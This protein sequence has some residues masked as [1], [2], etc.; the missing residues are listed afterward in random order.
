MTFFRHENP[1]SPPPLSSMGKRSIGQ[2]SV[3]LHCLEIY[4]AYD[5]PDVDM[6][7]IDGPV[8]VNKQKH[9]MVIK[10]MYSNHI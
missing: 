9:L 6:K 2:K 1:S 10:Q 7:V 5:S 8:L 4:T 3:V